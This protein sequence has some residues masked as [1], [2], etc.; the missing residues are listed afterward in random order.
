MI[1]PEKNTP[2]FEVGE[3]DVLLKHCDYESVNPN[4]ENY[5]VASM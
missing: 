1:L 4:R 3:H 2:S 5:L